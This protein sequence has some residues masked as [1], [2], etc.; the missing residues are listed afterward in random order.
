MSTRQAPPRT[1]PADVVSPLVLQ[2]D[3]IGL[4]ELNA[5]AALQTRTDRKYVLTA[6]ETERLLTDLAPHARVLTIGD[7]RSFGYASTYFDTADL[8]SYRL[9]AH[10]R[11]RRFKV[12]TRS[13]LDSGDTF[14]EVK[15]RAARGVMVKQ[16]CPIGGAGVLDRQAVA[17]A[18][19]CLS[20]QVPAP[21]VSS[22]VPTLTTRYHRTTLLLDDARITLDTGLTWHRW[23]PP[24]VSPEIH[25][26]CGDAGRLVVVE[27]KTCGAPS[28]ADRRL[29]RSG[30]R[31]DR[32][33][34]YA[35]GLALLDHTLPDLPWRR[36]KRR[37]APTVSPTYLEVQP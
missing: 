31:P 28:A 10:R 36:I 27:T 19:S 29:W 17:F 18:D 21:P 37:L 12:R 2:M 22:L 3:R 8:L 25:A 30:H 24:G 35:T 16:R 1:A 23:A 14:L 4:E 15:T 13:Y 33:S 20:R 6:G 11:R 26:A 34:K 7:T 9:A 5:V 32:I